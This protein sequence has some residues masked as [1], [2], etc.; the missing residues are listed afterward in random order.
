MP[1]D[2]ELLQKRVQGVTTEAIANDLNLSPDSVR[3]RVSRAGKDPQNWLAIAKDAAQNPPVKTLSSRRIQSVIDRAQM[4]FQ[5]PEKGSGIF[6]GDVHLPYTRW[7]A[8]ALVVQIAEYLKPTYI[9]AYNDLFDFKGMGRW[10]DNRTIA[11]QLWSG[12]LANALTVG[13]AYFGALSAASPQTQ[14]PAVWGNHDLWLANYLFEKATHVGENL[15]ADWFETVEG[16]GVL[17]LSHPTVQNTVRL[18]TNLVWTH[19]W[20]VGANNATVSQNTIKQAQVETG[21]RTASDVVTGHLHRSWSHKVGKATHYSSPCLSDLTPSYM[22]KNPNWQLG[23]TVSHWDGDDTHSTII[24]FTPMKGKLVA[25]YDG[26]SFETAL[27]T[28]QPIG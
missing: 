25:R 24:E 18:S 14:F 13:E 3:G 10:A 22:K 9:S 21:T 16:W 17:H 19:G 8:I 11:K 1:K 12:D 23:C 6:A 15:L 7:D 4:V 28:S 26:V 2:V 20:F 27:D 5:P